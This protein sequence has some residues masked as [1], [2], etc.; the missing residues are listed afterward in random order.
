MKEV[1]G[2][3]LTMGEKGKFIKIQ[4][5]FI[6]LDHVCKITTAK[7]SISFH[8]NELENLVQFTVEDIGAKTLEN[9]KLYLNNYIEQEF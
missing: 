2:T 5:I 3:A 9:V 4:S 6:N 8:F 1:V 7:E